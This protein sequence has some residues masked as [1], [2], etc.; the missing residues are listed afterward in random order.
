MKIPIE[1]IYYLLCYAWNKLDEKDRVQVSAEDI[2]QLVDLFAKVLINGT[3]ILLKRGLEKNYISETVELAGI[4]GKL[5]LS[6]TLKAGLQHKQR[7]LCT[8]DEFSA[9]IITNRIL[10][11]T[12]YRLLRI[13]EIDR[14]LRQQIKSVIRMLPVVTPIE[15]RKRDFQSIRYHRNNRFYAF[16]MHICEMIYDN[17]LPGK[18]AGEINFIDFTRDEHKMNQL[19]EA[20][21]RNY[22]RKKHPKWKVSRTQIKW[23]FSPVDS[24]KSL[25][26]LPIMETDITIDQGETKIIMD[27]KY[28]QRTLTTHYDKERIHSGNL[29]QLFSYLLNQRDGTPKTQNA[30]GILLYPTIDQDYDLAYQYDT[31]QIMIK[32]LNLNMHWSKIEQRL[33]EV[34]VG[35]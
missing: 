24:E 32:T 16:L 29:Y 9:D 15:L 14:E 1:N 28:Y 6:S 10:V 20:F 30:T 5:E 33:E 11:S 3:R 19:F 22:Y 26:Y 27:A 12:L 7:T 23:Q 17:T 21:I 34:V 4:K 31:H 35:A 8:I 25:Q 18:N 13:K 2:T